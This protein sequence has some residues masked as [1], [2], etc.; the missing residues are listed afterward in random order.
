MLPRSPTPLALAAAAL[1]WSRPAPVAACKPRAFIGENFDLE[2]VAARRAGRTAPL[3]G[4]P[5]RL[6]LSS[7]PYD[8][9]ISSDLGW[10]P[11]VEH[12]TPLPAKVER[13]I[14]RHRRRFVIQCYLQAVVFYEPIVPGRFT[15]VGAERTTHPG[16][17]WDATWPRDVDG[18]LEV[19]PTRDRVQLRIDRADGPLELEYRLRHR[20]YCEVTT[21]P[22]PPAIL[23]V[24]ALGLRRRRGR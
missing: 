16:A 1:L 23:F 10:L 9:I 22:R 5:A 13:T 6:D 8:Q 7:T 17:L 3:A 21:D 12:T 18:T 20:T 2:L 15:S 24:L 14:R 4:L 11:L 19:L